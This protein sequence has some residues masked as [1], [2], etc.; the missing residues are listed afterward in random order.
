MLIKYCMC[1][2]EDCSII[3]NIQGLNMSP[4][5]CLKWRPETGNRNSLTLFL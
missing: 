2:R 5:N 3:H 1:F 4:V